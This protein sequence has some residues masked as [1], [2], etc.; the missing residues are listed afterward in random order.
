MTGKIIRAPNLLTAAAIIALTFGLV[1]P[2]VAVSREQSL[3]T[4]CRGNLGQIGTAILMYANDNGNWAP[5]FGGNFYLQG[6][7][8]YNKE[9]KLS[10][11]HI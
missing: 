10:L 11:I 8:P 6:D 7:K 4:T 1:L 9:G 5:A 3:V 2:L